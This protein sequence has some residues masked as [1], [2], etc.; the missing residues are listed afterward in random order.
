[1]EIR[2]LLMLYCLKVPLDR[3]IF[4]FVHT[5]THLD[6]L[7]GSHIEFAFAIILLKSYC[8]FAVIVCQRIG[9]LTEL[10]GIVMKRN[11]LI[12]DIKTNRRDDS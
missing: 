10:A 1:M 9:V 12:V 3:G 11:W 4:A 2:K 7:R 8:S 6:Q 5:I